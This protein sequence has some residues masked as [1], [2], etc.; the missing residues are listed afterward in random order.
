MADPAPPTQPQK[1][2]PKDPNIFQVKVF[3]PFET[4]FE[5]DALSL[6]A[7]N[8]TGPF[9]VLA[10]HANFLTLLTPCVVKISTPDKGETS[11]PVERGVLRVHADSA[12]L[13]LNV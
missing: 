3:S 10:G 12:T 8:E 7:V 2:Q 11:L 4:F 13:F 9:D 5:G 1:D 6:S